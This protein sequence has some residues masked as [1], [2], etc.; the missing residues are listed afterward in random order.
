MDSIARSKL[1]LLISL[2]GYFRNPKSRI[3]ISRLFAM[4]HSSGVGSLK[5]LPEPKL[6]YPTVSRFKGRDV[7]NF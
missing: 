1:L 3:V 6:D 5:R 2:L 7:A 4:L